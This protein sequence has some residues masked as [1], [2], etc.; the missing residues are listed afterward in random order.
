MSYD[1]AMRR[2]EELDKRRFRA[3][4]ADE[5]HYLKSRES[6]RSKKLIPILAS[7]RRVILVSG[8]P[9]L[10]RPVEVYNLLKAVRPDVICSFT[11]FTGRYCDPKETPYGMDYTGSANT[12]ELH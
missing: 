7:S 11:E 10:N 4:I 3:C 12:R 6:Q 5:A 9:M 8:T 2:A 1:L